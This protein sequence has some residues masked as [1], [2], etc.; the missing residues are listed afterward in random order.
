MGWARAI[1]RNACA[2]RRR[3]AS[4]SPS[5][6]PA[7]LI[8][9]GLAGD[10]QFGEDVFDDAVE[11]GVLVG[12]V[13][14]DPHRVAV[15]GLAEPAH[16]ERFDTVLIDDLQ[17]GDQHLLTGQRCRAAR[18]WWRGGRSGLGGVGG[19]R[20]S[21]V[22]A[23]SAYSLAIQCIAI[24]SIY[25]YVDRVSQDGSPDPGRGTASAVCRA[26]IFTM[27]ERYGAH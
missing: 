10:D 14:V 16:R 27:R 9:A 19:H 3:A 13:A 11:Q 7:F 12:G 8:A 21:S 15:Q 17:C 2:V 26:L 5:S 4:Q 18:R 22:E 1:R 20:P 6:L 24:L 25:G 23:T